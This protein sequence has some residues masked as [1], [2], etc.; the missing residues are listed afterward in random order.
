MA[1]LDINSLLSVSQ[2]V[3]VTA[4]SQQVYDVAGLG[5]GVPVT[6]ITGI[7]N[8]GVAVF[9][10]DLGG[11]GPN[12]SSP[13]LAIEVAT[14]FTAAGAATMQCQLQ[15]AVDDGT[16]NPSTWKTIV[17]TDTIAV[18]LLVAGAKPASFNVPDR[19]LGQG[20]PRFYRTNYVVATGPMTAGALNARLQTG[21][22]DNP[23]YPG[24]F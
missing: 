22:D 6:N 18:A 23:I 13:Q 16:G 1:I 21:I 15:A 8:G 4:P 20:F 24:N 9:G 10:E 11:G 14:T 7:A 17:E 12:A 5:V 2:A 3:T 19:Y